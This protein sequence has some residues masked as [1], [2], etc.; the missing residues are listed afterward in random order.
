MFRQCDA[1]IIQILHIS[2]V[3]SLW[4]VLQENYVRK[5]KSL[6]WPSNLW[7]QIDTNRNKM[8]SQVGINALLF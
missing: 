5:S 8:L 4:V 7:E 6:G 1:F 2:L 3:L